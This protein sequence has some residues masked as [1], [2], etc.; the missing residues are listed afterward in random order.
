MELLDGNQERFHSAM[1]LAALAA[2]ERGPE[3]RTPRRRAGNKAPRVAQPRRP[4]EVCVAGLCVRAAATVRR[5][6]P[7]DLL[8]P[9]VLVVEKATQGTMGH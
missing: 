9:L 2:S 4:T 7:G 8:P 5:E 3:E 1:D 6:K